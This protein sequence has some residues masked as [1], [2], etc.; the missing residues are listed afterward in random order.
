MELSGRHQVCLAIMWWAH[1]LTSW[2]RDPLDPE[3][4]IGRFLS[5]L[6]T[7]NIPWHIDMNI[8]WKRV[9]PLSIGKSWKVILSWLVLPNRGHCSWTQVASI[10]WPNTQLTRCWNSPATGLRTFWDMLRFHGFMA[11]LQGDKTHVFR[12]LL[13]TRR[14]MHFQCAGRTGWLFFYSSWCTKELNNGFCF[15][16][17]CLRST[18]GLWVRWPRPPWKIPCERC[19]TC[20]C[21]SY[22]FSICLQK[23]ASSAVFPDKIELFID[24]LGTCPPCSISKGSERSYEASFLSTRRIR[25]YH[26][27]RYSFSSFRSS[28][29]SNQLS[30]S[31]RK[32]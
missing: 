1:A 19:T 31:P 25:L 26:W 6:P 32:N 4:R 3:N 11:F 12:D 27:L 17:I 13:L 15:S 18:V 9:R 29:S 7:E 30:F 8:R 28:S 10:I 21:W 5:I 16:N 2:R 22:L 24:C 20:G 23:E 14:E